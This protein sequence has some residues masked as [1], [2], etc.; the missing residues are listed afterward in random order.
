MS[1][2]GLICWICCVLLRVSRGVGSVLRSQDVSVTS[3]PVEFRDS[4]TLCVDG[5]A[6]VLVM[7]VNLFGVVVDSDGMLPASPP[8]TLSA[9]LTVAKQ[10]DGVA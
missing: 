1:G 6:M 7:T 10:L 8:S 9:P 3:L 5:V 2:L 4:S